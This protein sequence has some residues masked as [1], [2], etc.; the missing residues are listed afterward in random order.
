MF[1]QWIFSSE[2]Y[3]A[4]IQAVPL[5]VADFSVLLDMPCSM[6]LIRVL[7]IQHSLRLPL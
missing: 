3:T 6:G 5:Y 2:E 4:E 7:A 1:T